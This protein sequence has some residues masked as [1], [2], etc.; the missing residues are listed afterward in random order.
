MNLVPY[1]VKKIAG[2]SYSRKGVIVEVLEEFAD[3]GLKCAKVEGWTHKSAESCAASFHKS[4]VH[5]KM[6]YIKVTVRK[7][8]VYLINTTIKED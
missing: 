2:V 5:F 1:D 4:I 7:G 8:E 6:S 3:S